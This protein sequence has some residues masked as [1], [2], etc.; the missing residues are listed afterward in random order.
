MST[1][2]EQLIVSPISKL[3]KEHIGFIKAKNLDG[4]LNQYAD[5]A[6]LISTLTEDRQPVYVQGRQ[7][8]KEFF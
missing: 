3:Y 5:D 2:I 4:L 7:A 1:P 8:L 6:L